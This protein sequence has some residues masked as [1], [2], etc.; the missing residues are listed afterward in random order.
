[1]V[2]GADQII[3]IGAKSVFQGR[4]VVEVVSTMKTV[5]LLDNAAKYQEIERVLLDVEG[6]YPHYIKREIT[7]K[8]KSVVEEV[9]FYYARNL[10]VRSYTKNGAAQ[11]NEEIKLAGPI[12][13]GLSLQFFLRKA[14]MSN[15]SYKVL[16]Y[17]NGAIEETVYNVALIKDN[18]NLG[19]GTFKQYFQIDH[20]K[21]GITVLIANTPERW[22]LVIRKNASF[23]KIEVKLEKIK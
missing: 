14:N 17:S 16:F 8:E 11:P 13:D 2:H 22:P 21:S 1:M 12:Q 15:G 9:T 20:F 19:C 5:G 7:E 6:I 4:E 23:G 10:A 3:K 18:L